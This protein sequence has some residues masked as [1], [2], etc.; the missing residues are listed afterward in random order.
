MGFMFPVEVLVVGVA[1]VICWLPLLIA[2]SA[3][4]HR[5]VEG[6]LILVF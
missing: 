4:L 6:H 5:N 1:A 2:H 3:Y